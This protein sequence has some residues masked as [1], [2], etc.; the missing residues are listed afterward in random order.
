MKFTHS[1]K[2]AGGAVLFLGLM[3]AVRVG[4]QVTPTAKEFIAMGKNRAAIEVERTVYVEPLKV[5][6]LLGTLAKQSRGLKIPEEPRFLY[7][8]VDPV[9]LR[10]YKI[11]TPWLNHFKQAVVFVIGRLDPKRLKI[12]RWSVSLHTEAGEEIKTFSGAGHPPSAFY[13][14]GRDR[15][16]RPVNI[17]QG[18]I[19]EIT[20]VDYY[21]ARVSL[22]QKKLVLDRFIWEGPGC[23]KAGVIQKNVFKKKR[24]R[25]SREGRLIMRE[26]SQLVDQHDALILDI[27]CSGPDLDLVGERARVLQKYFAKENLRLKKIRLKS[28]VRTDES[29]IYFVAT[30]LR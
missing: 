9:P 5:N 21:G 7:Q 2:L 16:H 22:P 8:Q 14:N 26:L 3:C 28:I 23:L 12:S 27:E 1:R 24:A 20:L 19:P 25:F 10:S 29:V 11:Y 6:F 15:E 17:G 30:W 13:W 4:A 18:F